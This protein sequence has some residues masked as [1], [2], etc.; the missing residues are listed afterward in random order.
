MEHNNQEQ[1]NYD[2]KDAQR[3]HE[4]NYSFI[5][6]SN[7]DSVSI[8]L[9]VIKN[10]FLIHGGALVS[11]LTFTSGILSNQYI[12][13]GTDNLVTPLYYFTLGLAFTVAASIGAYVTTFSYGSAALTQQRI[14]Q[15]PYIKDT[16]G[17]NRW[18]HA[19]VCFH[20]ITVTLVLGSLA[21]FVYGAF[22]V[23]E[24]IMPNA[25][26]SATAADSVPLP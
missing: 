24:A 8:G 9:A 4:L 13:F 22:G 5:E 14:W 3:A 1:I 6:Q 2:R 11:L 23:K 26:N 15:Y 12:S 10:L 17:S 20:I 19:G 21:L 7:A 25:H 18:R 16:R